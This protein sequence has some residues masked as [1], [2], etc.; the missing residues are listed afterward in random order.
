MSLFLGIQRALF[1]IRVNCQPI[2]LFFV[3][4]WSKGRIRMCQRYLFNYNRS[5]HWS[6]KN[7]MYHTTVSFI[8][9]S[10]FV[11]KKHYYLFVG[12]Y[13]LFNLPTLP[14]TS[15]YCN[16]KKHCSLTTQFM[17]LQIVQT[18]SFMDYAAEIAHMWL[19]FLWLWH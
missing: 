16:L 14:Q 5:C 7:L 10:F 15:D 1:P 6:I 9:W 12:F 19:N 8:L 11:K 4:T 13:Y 17:L 2:C 3:N 18:A